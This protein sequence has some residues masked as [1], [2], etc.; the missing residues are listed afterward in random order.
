MSRFN[1]A[2]FFLFFIFLFT[3]CNN[4]CQTDKPDD[5]LPIDWESYNSVY[6]VYWNFVEN[7]C[8][9]AGD[10]GKT[11]M[12]YGWIRLQAPGYF[13][14]FEILEKPH[15]EYP[16]NLSASRTLRIHV[17]PRGVD[18]NDLQTKLEMNDFSQKCYIKGK[19]VLDQLQA[20]LSCTV[21]PVVYLEKLDDIYFLTDNC[22]R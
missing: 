2:F 15:H 20:Q 7:C 12:V 9:N 14:L 17:R 3:A 18:I 10:T 19:L 13:S 8:D 22:N 6:N 1:L 21:S 16:D 5:V 4:S 11:I